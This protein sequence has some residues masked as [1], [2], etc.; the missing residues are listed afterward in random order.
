MVQDEPHEFAKRSAL[1]WEMLETQWKE[2][3]AHL[4]LAAFA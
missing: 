2:R 4:W 1:I 3:G